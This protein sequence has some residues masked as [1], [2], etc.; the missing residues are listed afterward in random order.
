MKRKIFILVA[1]FMLFGIT[2]TAENVGD[3]IGA[4]YPTDIITDICGYEIPAYNIGGETAVL[5]SA[6]SNYGFDVKFED[7]I[8]YADY[9]WQKEKTPISEPTKSDINVLYTDIKVKINGIE[10]PAFNIDGSMA[11]PIERTCEIYTEANKDNE[12]SD[13]FLNYVWCEP[14]KTLSLDISDDRVSYQDFMIDLIKAAHMDFDSNFY[15]HYVKTDDEENTN[16]AYLEKFSDIKDT[17]LEKYINLLVKADLID[18]Y[19]YENGSKLHPYRGVT[20]TDAAFFISRILGCSYDYAEAFDYYISK[21][22]HYNHIEQIFES[23]KE[24]IPDYVH[25]D[26]PSYDAYKIQEWSKPY[27]A[28]LLDINILA[29]DDNNYIK[30]NDFLTKDSENEL[31]TS[32]LKYMEEGI[33]DKEI[34]FTINSNRVGFKKDFYMLHS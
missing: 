19:S 10:V 29:F 9:D 1:L 31:I 15:N 13:F 34:S 6:L 27:F 7:G 23:Y 22:G 25:Y 14:D 18:E 3:V 5:V 30:P 2:A 21:Y 4:V 8:A 26:I 12:I 20:R 32:M 11:I 28:Y 24:T 17:K 16:I 33:T